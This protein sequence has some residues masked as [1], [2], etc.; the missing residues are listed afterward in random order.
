MR[1]NK[2]GFGKF[3]LVVI[4]II[5]IVAIIMMAS[6][7]ANAKMMVFDHC[8]TTNATGHGWSSWGSQGS[9]S[10]DYVDK[11]EGAASFNLTTTSSGLAKIE[12]INYSHWDWSGYNYIS[13]WGKCDGPIYPSG[14]LFILSHSGGTDVRSYTWHPYYS[15][16]WKLFVFNLKEATNLDY[17]NLQRITFWVS[18]W[19][20]GGHLH[21]DYIVLSQNPPVEN[22]RTHEIYYSIQDAID[23]ASDGDTLKAYA[24]TFDENVVI[25]KNIT[26]IGE[27][28][29]ID[30]HGG[31][32]ILLNGIS[33][34]NITI[35]GFK[36]HN[37][38]EGIFIAPPLLWP[39][40]P[41]QHITIKDC[42]IYDCT[43]GIKVS[44][45]LFSV[46]TEINNVNMHDN[47]YGIYC[48]MLMKSRIKNCQV[49]HNDYGIYLFPSLYLGYDTIEGC[50]IHDNTYYGI[51]LEDL[52][53]TTISD[54]EIYSNGEGIY[55]FSSYPHDLD[56]TIDNVTVH[57]N[58]Y[59]GIY[60]NSSAYITIKN[61]N[62]YSNGAS[63][64][65][66]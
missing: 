4:G 38:T 29:V 48:D 9:L 25:D 65:D 55:L 17:S 35:Q 39:F 44:G 54:S 2:A 28:A 3:L 5:A 49:H 63:S 31:T 41:Y 45:D 20:S 10:L 12:N 40:H 60:L 24:G 42:E 18:T 62:V 51:Y 33:L 16:E 66:Y 43:Y 21:I 1:E 32:G 6:S 19:D 52:Y 23:N 22:L 58:S 11:M 8:D 15:S 57:D 50:Q 13:F 36:I 56:D 59:H 30:A 61:S 26:L 27:N 46:N 34:N 37:G 7:H 64:S 14:S 47:D 53:E